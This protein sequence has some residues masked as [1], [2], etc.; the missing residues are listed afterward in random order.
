RRDERAAPVRRAQ[1]AAA[2]ASGSGGPAVLR[3]RPA[4]RGVAHGAG[5]GADRGGRVMRVLVAGGAGFIG[6]HV[7]DALLQGDHEVV[8]LDNLLTGRRANV[9]HLL[10]QPGFRFLERSVEETPAVDVDLVLHLASP[11]SP[12]HYARRPVETMSAN[13]AGTHRLLE[14]ARDCN[15][16]LVYASTSEVYGD[17]EVHPQ[18]EDYWGHVNPNGPRAC[19]DE[20]KRFG[21]ALVFSYHRLGLINCGV[22]RIFNTYGPRMAADDGRAVPAFIGAALRGERLPVHG[23]GRQTRSFCYVSDLVRGLLQVAFDRHADGE[24]FNLGNPQEVSMLELADAVIA[25]AGGPGVYFTARPVDDPSRRRPDI[26]RIRRRY[27]WRPEVGLEEGL[28]QTVAYFRSSRAP[29]LEAAL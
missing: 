3:H 4:R 13:S 23:D 29:A 20:A 7:C 15:A 21:E 6:S 25:A 24:V 10:G 1:R 18:P 27:G 28:R 26:S 14:V 17:P 12:V 2:R 8:C 19:Y 22:V 16:R 5:C 9:E 11:A